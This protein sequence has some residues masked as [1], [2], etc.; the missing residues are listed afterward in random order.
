MNVSEVPAKVKLEADDLLARVSV[1]D[2]PNVVDEV[3]KAGELKFP[4]FSTVPVFPDPI[5]NAT[6]MIGAICDNPP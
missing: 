1:L 2:S 4:V 5:V 3:V 6:V